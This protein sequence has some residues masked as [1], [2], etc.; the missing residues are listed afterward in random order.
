MG[1]AAF[2]L[3][4][5]LSS[6]HL[7]P[8]LSLY[9]EVLIGASLIVIGLLGLKEAA[10]FE[11]EPALATAGAGSPGAGASAKVCRQG[12]GRPMCLS[13]VVDPLTLIPLHPHQHEQ[14]ASSKAVFLN[15]LLHGFSWDGT[16]TLAPA[17][18]FDS[19]LPVMTFLCSY[20]LGTVLSMSTA[21]SLIG[22]GT[23]KVGQ[24]LDKP[25]FPKKLAQ[26][27]SVVAILIGLFWTWKAIAH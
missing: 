14:E 3:K 24:A 23:V 17:L 9:T 18:A 11:A 8:K 21:T 16:P 1:M 7:L 27:S 12:G 20:G 13:R 5:R 26:G 6:H 15:G 22:E 25:T 19:W 10:N 4:G 2:F